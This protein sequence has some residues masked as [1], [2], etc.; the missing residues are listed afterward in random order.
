VANDWD[1]SNLCITGMVSLILTVV[2][3]FGKRCV[4]CRVKVIGGWSGKPRSG[5]VF[6]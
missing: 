3:N 2:K 5:L 4:K 6:G 1:F